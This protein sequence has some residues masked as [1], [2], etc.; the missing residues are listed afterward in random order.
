MKRSAY[1]DPNHPLLNI[2][3]YYIQVTLTHTTNQLNN[4]TGTFSV[5]R[6]KGGFFGFGDELLWFCPQHGCTGLI[7]SVFSLSEAQAERVNGLH[8]L[9]DWPEDLRRE[10]ILWDEA[11][12]S[13]KVCGARCRRS[14]LA[15]A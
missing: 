7:D 6:K 8:D 5:W 2:A 4:L 3:A 10:Y 12:T 13:C 15:D 9:K 1:V 11:E 14:E